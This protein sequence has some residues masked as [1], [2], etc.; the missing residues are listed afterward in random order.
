MDRGWIAFCQFKVSGEERADSL[1]AILTDNI[2]EPTSGGCRI[3]RLWYASFPRAVLWW[4]DGPN[5][6]ENRLGAVP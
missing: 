4:Q 2:N 1:A 3:D 5:F 6:A